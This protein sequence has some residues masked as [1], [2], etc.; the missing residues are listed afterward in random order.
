MTSTPKTGT[1]RLLTLWTPEDKAFWE[2]QGK[3]IANQNL[4]LSIPALFLAFAVWM[5]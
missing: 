5:V 2:M 4:W 3:A 1:G